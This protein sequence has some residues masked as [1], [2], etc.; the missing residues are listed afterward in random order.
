MITAGLSA[1][2][3]VLKDDDDRTLGST[4]S[5]IAAASYFAAGALIKAR[6]SMGPW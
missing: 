3:A 1:T 4:G 2:N 6:P 5:K